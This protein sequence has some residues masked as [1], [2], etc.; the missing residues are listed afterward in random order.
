MLKRV[1]FIISASR[2]SAKLEGVTDAT[3]KLSSASATNKRGVI[4]R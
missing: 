3:G 4:D 2:N 1:F